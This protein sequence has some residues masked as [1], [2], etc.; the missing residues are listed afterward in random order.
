[1]NGTSGSQCKAKQYTRTSFSPPWTTVPP[2]NDSRHLLGQQILGLPAIV[3]F[4]FPVSS[5]MRGT[6]S[7][8]VGIVALAFFPA[9]V[10]DPDEFERQRTNRLMMPAVMPGFVAA[11]KATGPSLEP[12]PDPASDSPSNVI[13]SPAQRSTTSRQ[14]PSRPIQVPAAQAN[15]GQVR[16]GNR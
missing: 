12:I 8:S 9:C 11:V 10:I 16:V 5:T 4:L 2:D 15:Y 3:G 13:P 6:W 7:A 14:K 1:M